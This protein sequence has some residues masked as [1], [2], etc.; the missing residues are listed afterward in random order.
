MLELS[1]KVTGDK[2]KAFEWDNHSLELENV[3]L[4]A[5][6]LLSGD[7]DT[8]FTSI[9]KLTKFNNYLT[10]GNDATYTVTD[11]YG[12]E[13][14]T[15]CE[16][17]VL[18]V[19]LHTDC[20]ASPKLKYMDGSPSE[21]KQIV[22]NVAQPFLSGDLVE[23]GH[24]FVKLIGG[25]WVVLQTEIL[26]ET[27]KRL[28]ELISGATVVSEPN[29]MVARNGT[30]VNFEFEAL[31]LLD[32]NVSLHHFLVDF[33]DNSPIATVAAQP[34]STPVR[35]DTV[36]TGSYLK[37]YPSTGNYPITVIGVDSYGNKSK[38]RLID[39]DDCGT[40]PPNLN[41]LVLHGWNN[42]HPKGFNI[43]VTPQG[44]VV[45]GNTGLASDV[46]YTIRVMS[47][48][49]LV[50]ID[51][52]YEWE[53]EQSGIQFNE[54]C[55]IKL[56]PS[57]TYGDEIRVIIIATDE[58]GVQS[59]ARHYRGVVVTNHIS[60]GG[61]VLNNW[62]NT[63]A[64]DTTMSGLNITGAITLWTWD[65]TDI[66]Y[67]ARVMSNDVMINYSFRADDM[68]SGD[69]FDM[70]QIASRFNVGDVACLRIYATNLQGETSDYKD[71]FSTCV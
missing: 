14:A 31:P 65:T 2:L 4:K 49:G 9:D 64:E 5:G 3:V 45:S 52:N 25:Y 32:E 16:G 43:G 41:N 38:P 1:N 54:Q 11:R 42:E 60:I 44:T 55:T 34:H 67:H 19:I 24:Y 6:L 69:T 48:N 47:G 36:Y 8:M 63:F 17:M 62:Q 21:L 13:S 70:T 39:L 22:D 51:Q 57:A 58:T 20:G 18:G 35:Y 15:Q 30:N 23:N 37:A 12:V 61:M 53:I 40:I 68:L 56:D 50:S 27:I 46:T 28:Q 33:G 66:R 10:G 7:D 71:Y 26:P 29:V 59:H